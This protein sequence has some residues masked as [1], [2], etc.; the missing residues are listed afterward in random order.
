M[1][2][3]FNRFYVLCAVAACTILFT[4]WALTSRAYGDITPI[5]SGNFKTVTEF[6]Q[7]LVVFGDAWSDN[8]TEAL[9]GKAWTD[10]LC[11]MVWN[12]W[13]PG[14]RNVSGIYNDKSTDD[15]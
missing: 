2:R 9:Q 8:E 10:W 7:R 12:Y 5:K 6:D 3:L 1:M 15:N 11:G 14:D 13:Y 4:A